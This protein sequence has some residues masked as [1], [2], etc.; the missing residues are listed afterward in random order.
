VERMKTSQSVMAASNRRQALPSVTDILAAS[1]KQA[2]LDGEFKIGGS[3]PSERELM[4]RF[5]VSRASVREALRSLGALGLIEVRRGRNG[6]SFVSSPPT[7]I[8]VQSLNMFIKGQDIRFIDLVFAREAI[9][10]A[11]AAQAALFRTEAQLETLHHHCTRCEL[12]LADVPAFVEANLDW[13]LAV[14]EASNNPLFITFLSSISNAMH[15]ATDREEF[16]FKTRKAVVGVHWQ[17]FNAIR[18]RDA[19]AAR[20]RMLRH[21]SAY[22]ERMALAELAEISS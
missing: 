14:T 18:D 12:T 10:P 21:L 20:R 11:A 7:E 8:V 17:I 15:T 2:I 4:S 1:L 22:R 5:D 16:D 19:E 3:L 13:H 9:E 6:G